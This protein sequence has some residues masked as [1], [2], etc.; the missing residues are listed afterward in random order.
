MEVILVYIN[1]LDNSWAV[2]N[3]KAAS[4]YAFLMAI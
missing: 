3:N 4:N 2:P 1:I